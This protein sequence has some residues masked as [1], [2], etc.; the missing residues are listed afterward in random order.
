MAKI[1]FM[2]TPQF[3]VPCLEALVQQGHEVSLCLCQP[4]K[5]QGRGQKLS[6]PPVKAYALTQGIEVF[7]PTKMKNEETYDHLKR[8][9]ADFFVVVAYGR[10]LPQTLLDLPRLAC[11]NVHASLLPQYRG[12]APIHFSLM[13]G[14]EKTGVTTMLMDAGMDTGDMLLQE[15]T[16]LDPSEDINELSA[17]LSAQGAKLLLETLDQFETITPLPQDPEQASYTRLLTKEDAK[18]DWNRSAQEIYDQQ[19]ALVK[20]YTSFR[21]KRLL[22]PKMSWTEESFGP[23]LPGTIH[24]GVE[25]ECN[26]S[27]GSGSLIAQEVQPE[28][29]KAMAASDWIN[30]FQVKDGERFES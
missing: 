27:T 23:S 25:R 1:V 30:G 29:K 10:I 6:P 18:I 5:K 2:G 9:Q 16:P 28:S 3:A 4:D 12:A 22:I 17:R 21:G 13:N 15:E 20:C 8:Q 19:R 7:Q 14:D 26:I 24:L 11:V